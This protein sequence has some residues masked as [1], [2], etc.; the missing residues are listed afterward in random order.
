[1]RPR[2]R[3]AAAALLCAA[4][5]ALS[6]AQAIAAP[7]DRDQRARPV[8]GG[9]AD[10]GGNGPRGGG[11]RG[12]AGDAA[13]PLVEG[14][15][16]HS[17]GQVNPLQVENPLCRT[18]LGRAERRNCEV[19]GTPEG[20]YPTSNYGFEIHIDTGVDNIVGNFQSLLAHIADAIWMALLFV[21]SLV[22]TLLGWA[23]ELSPFTD[24]RTMAEISRGLERFYRA[25]TSPWL[26]FAFVA[27]GA[28]AV[29][30][31]LARRQFAQAIAGSLLTVALMVAALA[32]LHEPRATVGTVAGFTN[33]ASQAVIAA[34]QA[35]SVSNPSSSYAEATAETWNAMTLPGFAALNFSDMGWALSR[36]DPQLLAKANEKACRDYAYLRAIPRAALRRLLAAGGGDIDCSEVAAVVPAPRTNAE[37]W[38]RNSPGSEARDSLWDEFTDDFP[39]SSYFAIQGDGGAWTRLPLVLLIGLGLLGGIALLAWLAIRIFVQT[40]VA[41]VLVLSTPLALFMPAFGER[42][43]AAFAFWAGTLAGALISKVIYAALLAVTLFA[44]NVVASLVPAGAG[45]FMG[46]LVMAGLWWAVFLKRDDLLSFLSVAPDGEGG[47]G[48]LGTLTGL[49][50]T[51]Q[52]ARRVMA[53]LGYGARGAGASARSGLTA[54]A[55]DRS[56]ATRKVA[57]EQ[58]ARQ[59][60]QRLA[61]RYQAEKGI[62]GEQAERRTQLA[63]LAAKRTDALKEARRHGRLASA[64]R[65]PER[66]RHEAARRSAQERAERLRAAHAEAKERIAQAGPR[67]AEARAFLSQADERQRASGARFSREEL[68]QARE[69]VR[70]EVDRPADSGVHAWRVG[71]SPQRYE[72]LTGREREDAQRQVAEQLRSDRLAFGAIPNRPAGLVGAAD[73]RRY[74]RH[75]RGRERG[76]QDL[77]DARAGARRARRQ[78]PR[79]GVSR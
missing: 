36:P 67:E 8:Q 4:A 12:V 69:A 24:N 71:L 23:F 44:T 40:A 25:F 64:A 62:L 52:L 16:E 47:S 32:I 42:G 31:G 45:A 70:R 21:L 13:A 50:A 35:G 15:E 10:P 63:R 77:H 75:V 53:P 17:L 33:D 55:R 9:S 58:L 19:T 51:Q 28:W 6:P 26:V 18:R 61:A 37:I 29:W 38:L 5:L 43:R 57:S 20:R 46:F 49:Y 59:A 76:A 54:L 79:R 56:G 72:S 14:R 60:E 22:L 48:R 7:G 2:P 74:R 66:E 68:G 39:Y 3:R 11:R 1:M 73:R 34:P 78:P 27:V 41:F 65:G 30:R